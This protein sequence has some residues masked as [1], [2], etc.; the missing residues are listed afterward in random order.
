VEH[1]PPTMGWGT[2]RR[3]ERVAGWADTGLEETP[4]VGLRDWRE[5]PACSACALSPAAAPPSSP[6]TWGQARR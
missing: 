6:E 3:E 4:R 5:C 2:V 1:N